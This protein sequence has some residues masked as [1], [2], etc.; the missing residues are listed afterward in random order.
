MTTSY[1]GGDL[2][3]LVDTKNG[4]ID[5]RIFADPEIYQLELERIFARTWNFMCHDSQIPPRATSS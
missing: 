2:L 5:R 4:L 3:E 1:Q